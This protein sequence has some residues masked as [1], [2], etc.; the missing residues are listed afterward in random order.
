M[1]LHASGLLVPLGRRSALRQVTTVGSLALIGLALVVTL[2][3][4]HAPLWV[5]TCA[6]LAVAAAPAGLAWWHRLAW[7][8]AGIATGGAT[9]GYLALL[10]LAAGAP[11]ASVTAVSASA[12]AL[13]LAVGFATSERRGEVVGPALTGGLAVL[14]T[15]YALPAWGTT[16]DLPLG[17]V[18]LVLAVYAGGVL[19][20]AAP[21]TRRTSSRVTLEL[22]AVVP[23]A[24]A[25]VLA[26]SLP[27]LA[28]VLTVVGTAVAAIAVRDADRRP[29]SWLGVGIL[30]CATLIRVAADVKAPELYTL[31]AALLL[32]GAGLWR[33]RTDPDSDSLDA[34]GSGLTLALLP[35][36]LLALEDPISTR[37]VLVGAAGVAALVLGVRER[38]ATP[39]LVGAGTTA[40]LALREMQPLSEAVPRWVS[41]ALLGLALLAVGITWETRLR[42]LRAAGRYLVGLR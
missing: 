10:G 31:P 15:T 28:M 6:A 26:P 39:L 12:L 9:A 24:V 18:A 21:V 34:L 30:G 42:N 2:V 22:T 8:E 16:L 38:L 4:T 32:L 3:S 20:A 27:D 29:M 13:V 33:L 5:V 40:L 25:A 41:L 1:V 17:T 11:S 14:A 37:G 36:L 7:S 19:L 35:S 23:A